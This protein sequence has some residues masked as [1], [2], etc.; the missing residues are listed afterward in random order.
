MFQIFYE[1]TGQPGVDNHISHYALWQFVAWYYTWKVVWK[2]VS[3]DRL[4]WI[5]SKA[6]YANRCPKLHGIHSLHVRNW[7]TLAP[8]HFIRYVKLLATNGWTGRQRL[9]FKWLGKELRDKEEGELENCHARKGVR[10]RSERCRKGK[11]PIMSQ[12]RASAGS[13]PTGSRSAKMEYRF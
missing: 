13:T 1:K 4:L 7:G 5:W 9:D 11:V 3:E 6:T 10:P 8:V 2:R 12:G